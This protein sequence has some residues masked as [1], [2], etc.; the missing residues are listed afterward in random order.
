M[1]PS[2]REREI[3]KTKAEQNMGYNVQIL[4]KAFFLKGKQ[5]EI[6]VEM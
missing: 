6:D 2:S 4:L 5:I 3:G 1:S